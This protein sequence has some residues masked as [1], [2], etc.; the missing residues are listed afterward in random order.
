MASN[1][2]RGISVASNTRLTR[3]TSS[4]WLAS[5]SFS[6]CA[7]FSGSRCSSSSLG[8]SIEYQT[9]EQASI[10]KEPAG[11]DDGQKHAGSIVDKRKE[12]PEPGDSQPI[13]ERH[14]KQTFADGETQPGEW[15]RVHLAREGAH[16]VRLLHR[17]SL[18]QQT[19]FLP[20]VCSF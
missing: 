2:A 7:R 12:E 5:A 17:Y 10:T 18:S 1:F 16:A 3:A 20:C 14:D 9:D 19:I 6:K 4:S 15:K 8:S 13:R 11:A